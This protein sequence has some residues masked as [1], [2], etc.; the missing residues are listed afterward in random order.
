MIRVVIDTNVLASGTF[1]NGTPARVLSSWRKKD[2]QLLVSPE[3]IEEY[4]RTL[5]KL[6]ADFPTV[7]IG[8]VLETIELHSKWVNPKPIR[9][10]CRDPDDDK[11]IAA[12][13][14]GRADF[15]ISGDQALLDV[16][17]YQGIQIL[18]PARFL[19]NRK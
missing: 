19:N 12:A 9:G 10:V 11:F 8:Q 5:G 16:G 2:F 7:F 15:I 6:A 3:I 14:A 4:Q 17:N 1:W 18:N 13:V